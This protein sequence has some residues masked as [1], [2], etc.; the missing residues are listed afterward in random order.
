MG[1]GIIIEL[2]I[3]IGGGDMGSSPYAK[4]YFYDVDFWIG[5]YFL[6]E[7][8]LSQEEAMFGGCGS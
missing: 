7:Y 6:Q 1:G 5:G 3:I 4:K 8:Q 2:G